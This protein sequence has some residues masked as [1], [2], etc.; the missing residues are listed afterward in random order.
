M[1]DGSS[2]SSPSGRPVPVPPGPGPARPA[3]RSPGPASTH[4]SAARTRPWPAPCRR[5]GRDRGPGWRRLPPPRW[6]PRP[7]R[8]RPGR[9][10]PGARRSPRRAGRTGQR[11]AAGHAGH[12][13]RHPLGLDRAADH[14]VGHEQRLGPARG[15]V[16]GH[17]GHQVHPDRV[18]DAEA[19]GEHHLGAHAVGGGGQHRVPVRGQPRGIE[20]PGEPADAAQHLGPGRARHR[21]PHQVDR[22]VTGV[23]VHARGRVAETVLAGLAGH[24]RASCR[25]SLFSRAYLP[26]STSST[27]IGYWPSKQARHSWPA[28]TVVA[29]IR[30][31]SEM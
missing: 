20:Q 22:T 23:D 16:V 9:S 31:S 6:L 15:Q 7:G 24:G 5:A 10:D 19:A 14:V 18:V 1:R 13:G 2:S 12:D 28:G 8:S 4:W 30:P 17:H 21:G 27:G 29:A 25:A 3:G 11:A 26:R